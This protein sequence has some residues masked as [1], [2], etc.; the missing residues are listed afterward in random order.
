MSSKLAQTR[1]H[2]IPLLSS[3]SQQSG[4]QLQQPVFFHTS[5]VHMEED[6]RVLETDALKKM[7]DT[8]RDSFMFI[9]VRTDEEVNNTGNL[10]QDAKHIPIHEVD[11]AFALDEE[12]FFN[13]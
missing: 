4:M 13:E 1:R 9:D 8:D 7:V 3:V 10:I 5:V 2:H 6:V 12:D 11:H